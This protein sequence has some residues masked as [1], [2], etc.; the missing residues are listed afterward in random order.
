MAFRRRATD[1]MRFTTVGLAPN[2]YNC[3]QRRGTRAGA[4]GRLLGMSPGQRC[5]RP[6][7]IDWRSCLDVLRPNYRH[8]LEA[9]MGIAYRPFWIDD[10]VNDCRVG[11]FHGRTGPF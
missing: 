8:N 2:R 7:P 4:K 10:R 11:L 5:C 9:C 6:V 3:L 1:C